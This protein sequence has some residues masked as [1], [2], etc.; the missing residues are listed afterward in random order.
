[1]ETPHATLPSVKMAET[2]ASYI[3]N[4]KFQFKV[5]L[6]TEKCKFQQKAINV[7]SV[8]HIQIYIYIAVFLM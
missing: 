6:R 2:L 7:F 3:C 1:M 4:Y 5:R 8:T